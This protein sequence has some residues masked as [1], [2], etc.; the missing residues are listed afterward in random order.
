MENYYSALGVSRTAT[1]EEIKQAYRKLALRESPG[2]R[3]LKPIANLQ[4]N[5]TVF[6]SI[7]S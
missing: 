7:L 2:F 1:A 3:V 6:D 4:G 5:L